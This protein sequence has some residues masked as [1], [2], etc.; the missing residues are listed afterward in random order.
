MNVYEYVCLTSPLD[1]ASSPWCG[2]VFIGAPIMAGSR[3]VL[4]NI[5]CIFRLGR[6][7]T[8]ARSAVLRCVIH[9]PFQCMLL[10]ASSALFLTG[11][12]H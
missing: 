1:N 9:D 12:A 10:Y 4:D 11:C 7:E 3:S 5:A 8:R 6:E 2:Q